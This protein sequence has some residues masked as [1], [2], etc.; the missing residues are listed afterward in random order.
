MLT[1]FVGVDGL[2]YQMASDR[3]LP[4]VFL[5]KNTWR[6]TNQYII[7]TFLVLCVTQVA[8]MRGDVRV[9]AGIY[10]IAFLGVMATFTVGCMLL[11][12][13]PKHT[14]GL[15]SKGLMLPWWHL[16]LALVMVLIALLGNF[17]G[18]MAVLV[19]FFAYFTPIY[20]ICLLCLYYDCLP[21]WLTP[22]QG[23]LPSFLTRPYRGPGLLTPVVL[24]DVPCISAPNKDK[25]EQ[26]SEE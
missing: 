6:G 19:F 8:I 4:L 22:N 24:V 17:L 20:G 16:T 23:C 9:L 14:S 13:S 12:A 25:D 18:L 7:I 1:A 26:S 15:V 3:A 21:S 11:K 10:S 2:V 5:K